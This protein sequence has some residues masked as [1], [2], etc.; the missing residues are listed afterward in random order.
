[1][2]KSPATP[3]TPQHI[4]RLH[5]P[6]MLDRCV[7]VLGPAL[8]RENATLV[9]GTLGMGGHSEAFLEAFPEL[10]VI[11]LDRDTE[12]I[13]LATRRLHRFGKRFVPVH[14]VYDGMQA[15]VES[16]GRASVSAVLLDLGVSSLQLD[17]QERGF[18]YAQN[19]PL[20]MRMNQQEGPTA[21]EILAREPEGRLRELFEIYGDEP[22][23]G[24]YARAIVQA[25][26]D[27]A[28]THSDQLVEI[29]QRATPAAVSKQRHPAKRVFQ[30]LRIEVNDELGA[31]RRVLPVALELLQVGGRIAVMSYQSL[32]D[33]LVKRAFREMTTSSAPPGLPVELPE[34]EPRFVA[35]TRKPETADTQEQQRNPRSIP[36]RFRALERMR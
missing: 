35:L 6:V 9:D 21:A 33:R 3:A 27:Q 20:D 31:L 32:E 12:A 14:T 11:G 4:A 13:S 7:E 17:Q 19:A 29:L 15:A 24:R 22:L 10:T 5:D 30:A 25:R 23:A 8:D 2:E 28:I 1:M 18:A 34:H 36:V 26:S 16:T